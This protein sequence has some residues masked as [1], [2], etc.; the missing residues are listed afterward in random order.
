MNGCDVLTSISHHQVDRSHRYTSSTMCT[1]WN[2][3]TTLPPLPR[4]PSMSGLISAGRA[5][6]FSFYPI[7]SRIR[8]SK[9][10]LLARYSLSWLMCFR[11]MLA[12]SRERS[13]R[14]FPPLRLSDLLC[15]IPD[16]ALNLAFTRLDRVLSSF[17]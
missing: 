13:K 3:G 14:L 12:F 5:I 4:S 11:L 10:G 8:S 9:Q 16:T 15:H 1:S 2:S 7:K 6:F 17:M